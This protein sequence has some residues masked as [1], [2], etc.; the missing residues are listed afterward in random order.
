MRGYVSGVAQLIVEDKSKNSK[1][2]TM[3]LLFAAD[4]FAGSHYTPA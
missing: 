1:A 3:E 2:A 4:N